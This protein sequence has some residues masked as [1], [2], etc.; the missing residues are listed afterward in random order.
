MNVG[1][2]GVK[3]MEQ[4]RRGVLVAAGSMAAASTSSS[5]LAGWEPAQRHPDPA[6]EVLDPSFTKFHLAL[7]SVEC[8]GTGVR[9][10]EGPVWF[11]DTRMLLFSDVPS[12]RIMKWDEDTGQFSVFRKPSNYANGNTR[13][14]QG[15]F[16]TCEH[17]PRRVSRTEYDGQHH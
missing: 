13:D 15:R 8:L 3:H 10:P 14:R 7:T 9:W 1:P 16:L 17:Q 6:V 12:N 2:L 5:V 4:T 11:G